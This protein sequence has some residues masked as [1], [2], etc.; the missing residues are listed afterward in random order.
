MKNVKYTVVTV[1]TVSCIKES[2]GYDLCRYAYDNG[3]D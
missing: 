1:L 3:E 2:T